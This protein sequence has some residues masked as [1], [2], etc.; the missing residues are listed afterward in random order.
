VVITVDSQLIM[1]KSVAWL[2]YEVHYEMMRSHINTG[3]SYKDTTCTTVCYQHIAA[4]DNNV[5]GK[6]VLEIGDCM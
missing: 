2:G 5:D 4:R 6:A 3:G 1:T